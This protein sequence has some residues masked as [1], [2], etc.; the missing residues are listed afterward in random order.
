M[1]ANARLTQIGRLT[2]CLRIEEGSPVAHVAPEM[3]ISTATG[4]K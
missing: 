1:H 3:G 4:Y 2:L